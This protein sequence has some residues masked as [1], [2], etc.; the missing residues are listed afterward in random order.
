M[1]PWRIVQNHIN[2]QMQF[3]HFDSSF[4]IILFNF[5]FIGNLQSQGCFKKEYFYFW[6]KKEKNSWTLKKSQ[7][8]SAVLASCLQTLL[9]FRKQNSDQL[10]VNGMCSNSS[11]ACYIHVIFGLIVQWLTNVWHEKLLEIWPQFVDA[12]WLYVY[13]NKL[14]IRINNCLQS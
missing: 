4:F 7:G 11:A 10:G 13:Q 6:W 8:H 5:S 2:Y 12:F 3:D 9:S 1:T 14:F